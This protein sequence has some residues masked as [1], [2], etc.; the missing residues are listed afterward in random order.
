MSPAARELTWAISGCPN[1]CSQPQLAAAGISVARLVA[2]EDG[3]KSPRFDLY[4]RTGAGL[5]TKVRE[6]LTFDELTELVAT[7]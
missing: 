3:V 4:R 7:F 1:S 6:Q 2:G 5:G